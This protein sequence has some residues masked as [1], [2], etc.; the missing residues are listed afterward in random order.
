MAAWR[1]RSRANRSRDGS[2]AFAHPR[3][4]ATLRSACAVS[5]S[6]IRDELSLLALVDQFAEDGV[7]GGEKMFRIIGGNDRLPAALARA[8][9]SRMRLE[10]MLRRVSQTRDG[11]TATLESNGRLSRGALRLSRVRH[12]RD[13]SCATSCSSR[14]CP[15]PSAQAIAA[16]SGTAPPRKPRCSSSARRGGN[17][18]SRARSERR[19]RL[20]PCGMETKNRHGSQLR[21]GSLASL[22]CLPA[23]ARARPPARC[24]QRTVRHASFASS[25]GST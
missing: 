14:R 17:A 24:S 6:P 23:A 4:C 16:L 11:V 7:P 20:A 9:G 19:Y 10:T 5:S 13:D 21:L 25:H 3:R 1:T 18:A 22:R 2:T 12:A 8:L 15:S